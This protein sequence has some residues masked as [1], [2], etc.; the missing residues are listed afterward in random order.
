MLRFER[1]CRVAAG[2]YGVSR[3]AIALR[4][5]ELYRSHGFRPG[6]ALDCGLADPSVTDGLLAGC[7]TKAELMELQDRINPRELASVTEDKAIFYPFCE[8]LGIPIPATYGVVARQGGWIRGGVPVVDR[9]GWLR[10]FSEL[11]AA[12]IAK[13]AM[14]VYGEAITS[15][16][17]LQGGFVDHEGARRTAEEL[18]DTLSTHPKYDRF[19]LQER[20]ENHPEIVRV[21]G[22][23]FL[24]TVRIATYVDPSGRADVLYAEWKLIVG[25]LVSDN[26]LHGRSGNLVANVA[27]ETG[28]LGPARQFSPDELGAVTVAKHPSTGMELE[29]LRLPDW[30]RLL[31]L[32]LRCARLFLPLRTVGWDIALTPHGP[33]IVEGNRW[34]DPPND[35]VIGP[36]APGVAQHEMIAAAARLRADLGEP[37]GSSPRTSSD[38]CV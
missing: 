29:G 22:C 27:R 25:N 10:A 5:L 14:G 18:Y 1:R 21:T 28:M 2:R 20:L 12:F 36:G 38:P 31:S 23:S 19:V 16:S 6:E 4:L 34:W 24:Q 33:V 37:R 9:A 15:W 3:G 26:F 13:P 11:P 32:A 7:F 35:S 8:A 30:E 17:R